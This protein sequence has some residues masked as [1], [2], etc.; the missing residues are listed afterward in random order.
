LGGASLANRF[1]ALSD[2]SLQPG[3]WV[4]VTAGDLCDEVSVE[5]SGVAQLNDL[6]FTELVELV[7]DGHG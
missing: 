1:E 3:C 4:D 2:L 6:A 5:V 7:G